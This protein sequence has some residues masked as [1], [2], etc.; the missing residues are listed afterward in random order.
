MNKILLC[1]SAGLI[2]LASCATNGGSAMSTDYPEPDKICALTFDDGPDSVKTGKVL[3]KLEAHNV[4]ATFFVVG[5]NINDGTKAVMERAKTM[6]CEFG[7]HSWN[8][9]SMDKLTADQITDY[10]SRTSAAIEKYTGTTPA[11][12]RPPNL[13]TSQTMFDTIPYT[14]ASGVL[15]YDWAGM[16]TGAKKR[17][18]NVI[19]AMQN[20]AIILLHDVQPDPHPTPEALDIIIPELKRQ[21][22]EFVTLSELF[23][24]QGVD[25][26]A[27][28]D[29]MW[30]VVE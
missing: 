10:I 15:G 24:R 4:V 2:V 29:R 3:D 5:Q 6:G 23:A 21:G 18:E 17:A 13:A 27:N 7:N 1:A 22:Y 25:P 9:S 14:F 28:Q 30:V 19:N 8:Y 20:G 11:F 26:A 12:F 16:N